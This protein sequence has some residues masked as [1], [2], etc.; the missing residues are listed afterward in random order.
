MF[1]RRHRR[2]VSARVREFLWPRMGWRRTAHY[3]GHRV[4]RLPG[5]PYS[6]AAGLAS[7]AAV[8]CTPF[9]GAHFVL[10]G[11]LALALRGNLIASAIGTAL[12]NPW[13]FPFIWALIYWTGTQIIGGTG[14]PVNFVATFASLWNALWTLDGQ[15]LAGD[16]WP[17]LAP[18]MVG[19][20]PWMLLV[21]G[22]VFWSAH[23]LIRS[24]QTHRLRRRLAR[25]SVAAVT[26]PA[27]QDALPV[28]P[29]S[30]PPKA[31]E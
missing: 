22:A 14:D 18:M 7:G 19:S 11:L 4:G 5:T 28:M 17:V 27:A 20:L 30:P 2:P 12:G 10:G 24:Y 29:A 26:A 3:L 1:Q 13:T 16:I 8:S 25:T 31:G 15:R 6:I 9:M 23:R 21:W